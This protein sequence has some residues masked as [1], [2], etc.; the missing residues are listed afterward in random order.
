MKLNTEEQVEPPRPLLS[1]A[2]ARVAL[3]ID[4]R[5][6]SEFAAALVP[7]TGD[8]YAQPGEFITQARQARKMTAHFITRAVLYERARGVS[9]AEI[10]AALGEDERW[11]RSRF[12]PAEEK[13]LRRVTSEEDAAE[14]IDEALLLPPSKVPVRD[15]DIRKEAELLDEWCIRQRALSSQPPVEGMEP[16]PRPV[17]DGIVEL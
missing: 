10:A 15:A 7:A 14:S 2:A 16:H 13:W 4:A 3:S 1:H 9:W 8:A 6:L 5:A 11:V 17:T 12:E